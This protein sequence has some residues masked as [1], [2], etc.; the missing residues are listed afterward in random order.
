M[1]DQPGTVQAGP[2]HPFIANMLAQAAAAGRQ[3]VSRGSVEQARA[4][5]AASR[6]PLGAG[7]A[8]EQVSD[9][10]IALPHATLPARVFRPGNASGVTIYLHGGGW[11]VGELDDFD[12]L[13]RAVAA[14]SGTTLVMPR[15]RLAPEHPFPAALDDV[16]AIL[17]WTVGA[18]A[19]LG[20]GRLILAG[21]SAGANLAAVAALEARDV[22][23]AAQ[24]LVYPVCDG[25]MDTP[26]YAAFDAGYPL[27]AQ[28]MSWFFDHYT[29]GR[30]AMR[31]DPRVSPLRR[32]DLDAAPPSLIVTAEHDILRDEAILFGERLAAA[33]VAVDHEMMVGVTHGGLRLFNHVSTAR[34]A[35]DRIGG[36]IRRHASNGILAR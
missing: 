19:V 27:G 13:G 29:S 3:P 2:L 34:D 23:V 11:V 25:S 12:A 22:E 16:V 7:P 33:G 5:L 17:R 26:S 35:I 14:A 24:V 18:P 9:I 36:F 8:V 30:T 1:T 28:D 4:M 21:D 32:V 15:Y 10:E 6:L 31:T 20:A